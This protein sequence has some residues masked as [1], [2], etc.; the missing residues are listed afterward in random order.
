MRSPALALRR[1]LALSEYSEGVIELAPDALQRLRAAAEERLRIMPGDTRDTWIVRASQYVGMLTTP[2]V[3]ILVRPK[4]PIENVLLLLESDGKPLRSDGGTTGYAT[5]E[6]LVPAFATLYARS[7]EGGLS[8]GIMRAYVANEDRLV[9]PRGRI[10]LPRHV[11]RGW[12]VLPT[13]CRFDEY[14]IDT[15]LNRVLRA[16]AER[17][18]RMSGGTVATRRSLNRSIQRLDGVQSLRPSDL[19]QPH[20]FSRLDAHL[21]PVERLARI[22]LSAG[23]V[24]NRFGQVMADAFFLDMNRL[25]E[26]FVSHRL[27]RLLQGR[28]FVDRQP[29]IHFDIAQEVKMFP[30]LVLRTDTGVAAVADIKYKV[31]GDGLGRTADYYQL[32]AYTTALELERGLLIYCQSD[33][34]VPPRE[35]VVRHSGHVLRTHAVRLDGSAADIE[36]EMQ[37]LAA[38]IVGLVRNV[39]PSVVAA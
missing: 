23:S 3:Q 18:A 22:A 31:A 39:A 28:C 8:S 10:D 13:S 4:V 38:E 32:L 33:G 5:D 37:R 36:R 9:T 14:E 6:E 25:F 20:V 1:T 24:T 30:D 26:D 29:S 17:L 2:D 7:L 19:Q 15:P 21:R 34:E 27:A 11:R 16:A 35:I 12:E